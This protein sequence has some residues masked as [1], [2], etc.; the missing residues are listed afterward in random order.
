M[1][2]FNEGQRVVV[3]GD[4]NDLK[5]GEINTLYETAKIAIV[6]FDDD[7]IEK[8]HFSDLGIVPKTEASE[9]VESVEKSEITITP[10]EFRQICVKTVCKVTEEDFTLG[11]GFT[12]F[13]AILHRALFMDEGDND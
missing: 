8:V 2:K 13:C 9:P 3:I 5:Y 1:S 10:G 12:L 4:N 11:L 6:R 7:T